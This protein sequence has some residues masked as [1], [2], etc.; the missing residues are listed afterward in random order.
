MRWLMP[1]MGLAMLLQSVG[2]AQ[3]GPEKDVLPDNQVLALVMTEN[4]KSQEFRHVLAGM[5]FE[6]SYAE[7]Y[8]T[9]R[10]KLKP[11]DDGRTLLSYEIQINDSH[12]DADGKTMFIRSGCHGQVFLKPDQTVALSEGGKRSFNLTLSAEKKKQ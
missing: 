10:G 6:V 2:I 12:K 3:A 11:S 8:L 4:G 7:P 5:E 9:F 1:V